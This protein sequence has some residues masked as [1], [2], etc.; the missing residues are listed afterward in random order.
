MVRQYACSIQ[1][2]RCWCLVSCARPCVV[3]APGRRQYE[4]FKCFHAHVSCC[5]LAMPACITMK[6]QSP[7]PCARCSCTL[8]PVDAPDRRSYLLSTVSA[9][10][11]LLSMQ[12][13]KAAE[14]VK[15]DGMAH[16]MARYD[17]GS[18][19]LNLI[20]SKKP[21]TGPEPNGQPLQVQLTLSAAYPCRCKANGGSAK[22]QLPGIWRASSRLYL[23]PQQSGVLCTAC[24]ECFGAHVHI[25]MRLSM[26]T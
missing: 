9:Y 17:K 4:P 22:H 5:A 26:M 13:R 11:V 14:K 2:E 1:E 21:K 7:V 16:E 12:E 25:L 24:Q 18:M 19:F 10:I 6:R 15:R 3:K 8:A 23:Q 20:T